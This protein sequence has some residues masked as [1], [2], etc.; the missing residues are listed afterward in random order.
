M[1]PMS[2]PWSWSAPSFLGMWVAMMAAMMLPSLAPGLWRYREAA[3]NSGATRPAL[4]AALV[5]VAYFIVW[6]LFGMAVLPLGT[7]VEAVKM[8]LPGLAR[9]APVVVGAVIVMAGAFQFTRWKAH[10]LA[11]C[12]EALGCSTLTPSARTAVRDG[13]RI[14]LHCC[15]SCFGFVAMLLAF[16]IM[17]FRAMAVVTAAIT[18]ERL[19]RSGERIARASGALA[20]GAGLMLIVRASGLA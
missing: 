16:G 5:G 2:G 9:A 13:L 14:G 7:A 10:H 20:M 1:D 15:H 19:A 3:A 12:R 11:G 18:A 8:Q 4:F 17:D 6:T